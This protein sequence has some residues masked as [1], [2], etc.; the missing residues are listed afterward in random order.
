MKIAFAVWGSSVRFKNW[1]ERWSGQSEYVA[2]VNYLLS[3]DSVTQ[4]IM[5]GR[6]DDYY[7]RDKKFVPFNS[8]GKYP[9]ADVA[10]VIQSQG[11]ACISTIQGY[12]WVPATKT[13][14]Y[15]R[16]K[17]LAMAEN[18]AAPITDY[19]N[20]TDI[21]WVYMATDPR[22]IDSIKPADLTNHP[23][24]VIGSAEAVIQKWKHAIKY[25]PWKDSKKLEYKVFENTPVQYAPL[26]K[27]NLFNKLDFNPP[28]VRTTRFAIVLNKVLAYDYRAKQAKMWL[29]KGTKVYGNIDLPEFEP[30]FLQP[31]TLDITFARTKYTLV[32]PLY[33]HGLGKK[34]LTFKPY[35]MIRLGVIPFIHPDYDQDNRFAS[36]LNDAHNFIRVKSPDDL[37]NKMA[38]LDSNNKLRLDILTELSKKLVPPL[39]LI[40]FA[41]KLA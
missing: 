3:L 23:S 16:T 1:D 34:W 37:N 9:K 4:V 29:P 24:I 28:R 10:Y 41:K 22:Y 19:L 32:M 21:P 25:V 6:H 14:P 13:E 12:R 27:L 30:E 31:E 15:R 7:P 26:Q 17:V 18:Y 8:A 39:D 11:A 38:Q 5:I 40:S 33:D 2:F 20:V 35:E 36:T